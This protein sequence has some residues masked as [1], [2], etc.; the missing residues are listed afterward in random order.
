MPI[1]GAVLYY[2]FIHL[3]FVSLFYCL[4][5]MDDEN[6]NERMTHTNIH[7]MNRKLSLFC[8]MFMQ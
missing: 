2:S 8:Q 4:Y 6:T 3:V 1:T 7:E 5:F